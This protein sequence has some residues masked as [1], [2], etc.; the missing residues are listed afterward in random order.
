MYV[1]LHVAKLQ[2]STQCAPSLGAIAPRTGFRCLAREQHA[3]IQECFEIKQT[4]L[5]GF[6]RLMNKVSK[7]QL[8]RF[9]RLTLT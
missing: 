2:F 4:K 9:Q 3:N 8:K 5:S 7:L 6:A 1:L